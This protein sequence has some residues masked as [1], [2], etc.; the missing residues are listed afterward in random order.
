MTDEEAHVLRRPRG[1]ELYALVVAMFGYFAAAFVSLRV[2]SPLG[3]DEAIYAL[4]AG[5]LNGGW[6]APTD[7]WADYRAPGLPMLLNALGR[8]VGI[9]VTSSR[10]LVTLLGSV[11]ILGVWLL[12][13]AL[14]SGVTGAV[15]AVLVTLSSGFVFSSTTLLADVPGA[16]FAMMAVVV[17][18]FEATRS[19]LY[20]SFL[21]VPLLTVAATIARFGAPMMIGAGLFAVALVELPSV[22][23]RR[24]WIWIGQSALLAVGVA[25]VAALIVLT[26]L[27]SLGP[28]SPAEAN[29]IL[30]GGK[31]LT[32]ASGLRD[33][34]SVVSPFSSSPAPLWSGPVAS[35]YVVGVLAGV[36][37]SWRHAP[38]RRLV[39]FGVIAGT[40][41]ALLIAITV[42]LV[43]QNYLALSVPFWALASGAGLVRLGQQFASRT[44]SPLRSIGAIAAAA[45]VAL[46]FVGTL[47]DARDLHRSQ[48]SAYESLRSV[49]LQARA[50][51][52]DDCLVITSSVPQV[53]YYTGCAVQRF[54]LWGSDVTAEEALENAVEQALA[55]RDQ[56][57]DSVAVMVQEG[58]KRQPPADE[59]I[60]G[61]LLGPVIAVVGEPGDGRRYVRL[62]LVDPESGG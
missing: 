48:Q 27:V 38:I 12:G 40:V 4:R 58:G 18:A 57:F 34:W 25:L 31:G 23:R 17:Y 37:L 47:G 20:W 16:A 59:F 51:L 33:L 42:G 43:V 55:R 35:L 56:R 5:D 15:G 14:G 30:V 44:E 50:L 28:L 2:R 49:S 13:R 9:H 53:G 29:S 8:V 60:E 6:S 62:H 52:D 36:V 22:L 24:D 45:V 10:I 3:H 7:G 19:R 1:V 21:A 46:L 11:V 26:D 39:A 61:G 32:A 54:S 41:S